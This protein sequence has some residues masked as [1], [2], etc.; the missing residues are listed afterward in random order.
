MLN[1]EYGFAFQMFNT[2][3]YYHVAENLAQKTFSI[4]NFQAMTVTTFTT[5]RA[6]YLQKSLLSMTLHYLDVIWLFC[7]R[8]SQ[9]LEVLRVCSPHS[10]PP[11][12]DNMWNHVHEIDSCSLGKKNGKGRSASW[13]KFL[14]QFRRSKNGLV[15]GKNGLVS[16]KRQST[17]WLIM[18]GQSKSK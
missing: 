7:S 1:N 11:P 6:I 9:S 4:A 14:F 10:L 18:E 13:I 17:P 16:G 5:L 8:F 3:K 15:S 2:F 12:I